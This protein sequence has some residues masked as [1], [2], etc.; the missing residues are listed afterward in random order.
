[1]ALICGVMC[2]SRFAFIPDF[3]F[4]AR[5]SKVRSNLY[6]QIRI[7][8]FFTLAVIFSLRFV[9]SQGNQAGAYQI[10]QKVNRIN[11]GKDSKLEEFDIIEE[12]ESIENRQ[13]IL[14]V[15]KGSF[16]LLSSIWYQTVPMFRPPYLKP[17]ALICF[18]QFWTVFTCNGFYMLYADVLNR[19]IT[20][21]DD[22]R[23]QRIMVCD[24]INKKSSV[25]NAINDTE[26][27]G[28]F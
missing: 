28:L 24:V 14:E 25:H 26:V 3:V 23:N 6:S 5:E 11:N 18:I 13:R 21:V 7:A 12:S 22:S 10:L 15:Q 2:F 1:M 27:G 8:R 16:P 4:P 9:L 20:N 19:M 17:T